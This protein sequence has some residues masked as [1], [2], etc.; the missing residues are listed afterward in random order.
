MADRVTLIIEI[1]NKVFIIMR[2]LHFK[3][4]EKNSKRGAFDVIETSFYF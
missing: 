4:I 1:R 3:K 2:T